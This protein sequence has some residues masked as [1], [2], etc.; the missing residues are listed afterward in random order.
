M[1]SRRP[2]RPWQALEHRALIN[3]LEYEATFGVWKH[4]DVGIPSE[5]STMA[6]IDVHH[7]VWQ[8]ER[9][10]GVCNT[11]LVAVMRSLAGGEVGVGNQ[12]GEGVWLDDKG[13]GDVWVGLDDLDDC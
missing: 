6:S 1:A 3:V 4:T 9:F 11:L 10:Q 13:N 7:D 2:C 12:V 8:I 5:P